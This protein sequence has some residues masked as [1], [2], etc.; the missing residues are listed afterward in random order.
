MYV[1][2]TC[3]FFIL[4]TSVSTHQP[5]YTISNTSMYHYY[6]EGGGPVSGVWNILDQDC[7]GPPLPLG[8]SGLI[9]SG[10]IL[11]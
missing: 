5:I 3:T 2:I 1:L 8:P 9:R 10:L 6:L 11:L 4:A 7:F